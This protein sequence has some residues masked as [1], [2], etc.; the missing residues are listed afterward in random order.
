[1]P[2]LLLGYERF[3][4]Q[5]TKIQSLKMRERIIGTYKIFVSSLSR[6][7]SQKNNNTKTLHVILSERSESKFCVDEVKKAKRFRVEQNRRRR[8]LLT[9]IDSLLS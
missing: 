6:C 7:T 2:R 3:F 4:S 8:D 1:M 5:A 9:L